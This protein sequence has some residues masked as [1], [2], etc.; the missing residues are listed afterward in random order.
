MAGS[1]AGGSKNK[2]PA[3][4]SYTSTP[5]GSEV[6]ELE[7]ANS[8]AERLFFVARIGQIKEK[9]YERCATWLNGIPGAGEYFRCLSMED[10]SDEELKRWRWQGAWYKEHLAQQKQSLTQ[11]WRARQW[12]KQGKGPRKVKTWP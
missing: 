7:Y 4:E 2:G 9:Q 10:Y 12:V 8:V 6:D 11:G 5:E 3:P 1:A